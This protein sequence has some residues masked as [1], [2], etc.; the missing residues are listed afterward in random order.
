MTPVAFT[1]MFLT[2]SAGRPLTAP[3]RFFSREGK[4]AHWAHALGLVTISAFLAA[5]AA[6]LV[7]KPGSPWFGTGLFIFNAMGIVLISTVSGFLTMRLFPE[8]RIPFGQLFSVYAFSG[9]WPI[10]LSWIPG[11]SLATEVWRWWLI[12]IGLTRGGGLS[13]RQALAIIAG[14]VGLTMLFLSALIMLSR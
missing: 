7:N 8:A 1:I 4:R 10:V 11:V 12:G 9:T 2:K 14:S 3:G 6:L 13:W 5:G